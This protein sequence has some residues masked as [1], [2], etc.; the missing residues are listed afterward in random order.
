M[1]KVEQQNEQI[2]LLLKGKPVKDSISSTPGSYYN[3]AVAV[4]L[5]YTPQ[6]TQKCGAE[7]VLLSPDEV[8]KKY[9]KYVNTSNIGRLAVRLAR[10]AYFGKELMKKS[11]ALGCQDKPRL[12][13]EKLDSLKLKL[14]SLFP[15]FA[16]APHE[17]EPLWTRSV[18][19]INHHAASL[20]SNFT[21]STAEL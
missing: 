20:R 5:P 1:E 14:L 6:A 12:P 21:K 9:P 17:F 7:E 4:D 10:E 18:A 8:I 11:T 2:L 3:A 19:A 16:A 13:K 15:Q